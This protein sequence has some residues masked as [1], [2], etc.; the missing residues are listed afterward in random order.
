MTTLTFDTLAY[1]KKLK[2]A[3]FTEQQ[4]DAQTAALATVLKDSAHDLAMKQD[5]ERLE[6]RLNVIEERTEGRFK[7]LQWMLGFN[8]AISIAL[9][10]ILIRNTN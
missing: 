4:A 9:L 10:W 3:G 8:L 5:I 7:L 6:A 1:A 2:E